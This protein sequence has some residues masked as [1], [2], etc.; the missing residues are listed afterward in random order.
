MPA[1]RA[2]EPAWRAGAAPPCGLRG[3]RGRARCTS[4]RRRTRAR[5]VAQVGVGD[6]GRRWRPGPEPPQPPG[7]ARGEPP[8]S[9]P[10]PGPEPSQP[11]P[12]FPGF[13]GARR[14]EG[15]GSAAESPP[16]AGSAGRGGTERAGTVR[17]DAGNERIRDLSVRGG[18]EERA[19]APL[20]DNRS[21]NVLVGVCRL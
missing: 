6:G 11:V 10:P 13:S 5:R 20:E 18:S 12:P 17:L 3:G 21:A 4:G 15:R 1:R 8:V 16:G 19:V 9:P 14:G 7:A 2:P